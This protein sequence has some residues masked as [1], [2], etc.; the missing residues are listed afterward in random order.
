VAEPPILRLFSFRPVQSAFDTVLRDVMVPDLRRFPE[1]LDLYLGRRGPDELGPRLIASVWSSRSGMILAVG[2][3]FDPPTFHPEYL[4][5]TTD[6]MLEI[7]PLAVSLRFE[8]PTPARIMRALRGRI[9]PGARDAYVEET[10]IGTLA[11]VAAGRGPVALHLATGPGDD[12][13]V[14]LSVWETWSDIEA[15]TGGVVDRPIATRHPERIIE[16]DASH[17]ELIEV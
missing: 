3:H 13:F 10:R 7:L 16:W 2:E 17:Y 5:A 14:T 8:R 6:R 15:A 11:D 1:L 9:R 12:D 4:D